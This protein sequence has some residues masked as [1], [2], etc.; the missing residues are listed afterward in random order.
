VIYGARQVG[1]TTLCKQIIEKYSKNKKTQYFDC[2]ELSI[3]LLFETTNE[4]TLRQVIGNN[5]LIILDEVQ[6]LKD[7]GKILKIIH[8]HIPSL[9]VIA[10]GS[11][12]FDLANK[13]FEPLT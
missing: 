1:K 6:T 11:S 10:T 9:Q 13:I 12:S 3:K 4:K 5:E 8:D 2:E 7:V